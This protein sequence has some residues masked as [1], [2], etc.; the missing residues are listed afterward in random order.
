MV[1]LFNMTLCVRYSCSWFGTAIKID[2]L[3][4]TVHPPY[5]SSDNNCVK[6][7]DLIN[8]HSIGHVK[9][10]VENIWLKEMHQHSS[11]NNHRTTSQPQPQTQV[12]TPH[13][14]QQQQTNVNSKKTN[15]NNSST[16]GQTNN[17]ANAKKTSAANNNSATS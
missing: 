1:F 4:V 2:T 13:P 7:M 16:S 5:Y 6:G 14:Q 15:N 11:S 10:V 12:Q 3:N 8:S 9:K 17:N